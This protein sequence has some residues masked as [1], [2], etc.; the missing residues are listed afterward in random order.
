MVGRGPW[1][2]GQGPSDVRGVVRYPL[3]EDCGNSSF[4]SDAVS[5]I[6]APIE[7]DVGTLDEAECVFPLVLMRRKISGERK[8][9]K[10]YDI[11]KTQGVDPDPV[12]VNGRQIAQLYT[13]VNGMTGKEDGDVTLEA[14][15]AVDA[16]LDMDE[17]SFE[18]FGVALKENNFASMAIMKPIKEIN[19]SSLLDDADAKRV[20]N[21]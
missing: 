6:K 2:L 4:L 7:Q 18:E 20:L 8:T 14:I 9:A 3:D 13:F 19:S 16:F 10:P 1:H 15:L 12:C 11:C 17:M 5:D 21:A